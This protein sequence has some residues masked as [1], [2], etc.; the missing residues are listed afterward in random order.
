M[1]DKATYIELWC[2]VRKMSHV[3]R[4]S[5]EHAI[6]SY[7]LLTPKVISVGNDQESGQLCH[8]NSIMD[9]D[10]TQVQAFAP[11]KPLVDFALN[12][13]K[14][15]VICYGSTG[16]GKTHTLSGAE[17]K[18]NGIIQQAVTYAR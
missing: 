14:C 7:F 17:W 8:F 16:S 1:K 6:P 11:V 12:G 10:T 2:K 18:K 4:A 15:S 13:G 3:E 9:Q 5:P